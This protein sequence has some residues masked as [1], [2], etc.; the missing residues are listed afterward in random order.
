MAQMLA[1][2]ELLGGGTTFSHR[3]V[4]GMNSR[5]HNKVTPTLIFVFRAD[6]INNEWIWYFSIWR[7]QYT[8]NRESVEVG[9]KNVSV[10]VSPGVP[11]SS[12]GRC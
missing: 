9:L 6:N 7:T 12:R 1:A 5:P 2:M 10:Q 11:R 4:K 8:A 3:L